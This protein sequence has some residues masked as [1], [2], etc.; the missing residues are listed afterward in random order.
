MTQWIEDDKYYPQEILE[1]DF[2]IFYRYAYAWLGLPEP[3]R[4]Q[5][6][7]ARFVSDTSNP[8]RMMMCL[9]G[10]AKS[11]TS[12]I[13]VTWRLLR[14][15]D[16]HILVM[17][18]SGRR[19]K[20]YTAFVKKLIRLLPATQHMTP[21]HNIER[22]SSES[23]DV[24]GAT[25]SD[26][27]SVYAVGVGNQ[28]AGFRAT[29][30]V[31]D[32]IES[33]QN[34]SS[35]IQREKVEH[36]ASEAH[37]LLISG[38]DESITLCTPHSR[39]S[40]YNNWIDKGHVPLIIPAEYPKDDTVYGD[41]LAPYL[42]ANL[43]KM[44]SLAGTP[45]D[46]RFDAEVLHSKKMRVGKSQYKLQYLLDTSESDDLKFPL[47][48]SDLIVTDVDDDVAPVKMSY[49]SMDDKRIYLKHNG[50]KEDRFF[51]PSYVS[52]EV[53]KYN[54][55]VMTIDPSGRGSDELAYTI[56]SYLNTRIFVN[57]FGGFK[58]GY[59]DDTLLAIVAMAKRNK[60][61]VI[62]IESNFGDGAFMKMLVPYL[63]KHYPECGI[64]EV[65]AVGQKEKRI[66]NTLEPIMNQHKLVIN[67]AALDRDLRAQS[68]YSLTYQLTHLT[69]DKDCL[70]H[71]DRLDALEM[72]VSFM[73]ESMG[74]DEDEGMEQ[75]M[76]EQIN[77]FVAEAEQLFE[78]GFGS[79]DSYLDYY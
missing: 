58:G 12:Q 4:A 69:Y 34:A 13:Y 17:S 32:D 16:E 51:A 70:R 8:H 66:I 52:S 1:E 48:L 28:I 65:R 22:T 38:R 3:T 64:E 59:D 26:S 5:I 36:Y 72:L 39:E 11:L 60:V 35:V 29:L 53:S 77:Q 27:P 10:L 43:K 42:R 14:D 31:Y 63:R 18:A 21:R 55:K 49:S 68:I 78:M 67:K 30:V 40:I 7:M 45:V 61:N 15:P 46:E 47:K 9:R 75:F 33:A 71:D 41:K 74:S 6:E 23:F 57:D 79:G 73:L 19:A 62:V 37:N 24:A 50:F 25:E 20:N 56:G 44:P 76:D 2:L 54:Y